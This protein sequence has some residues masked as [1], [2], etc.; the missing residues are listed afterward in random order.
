MNKI[1]TP[2]H[3]TAYVVG[4]FLSPFSSTA[5]DSDNMIAV[6]SGI[7][8]TPAI[9]LVQKY[10]K[11]TLRRV[12][13]VWICRDP[14]LVEH[15]ITNIA[16][17]Q[18]GF[19]LIYYTG[20]GRDI[21]LDRDLPPNVFL[22]KG[23]PNLHQTL[24]GIIYSIISGEGLPEQLCDDQ[25]IV[26]KATPEIRAKL[27]IEKAL[28]IY[29]HAQ[30][31]QYAAEASQVYDMFTG[32]QNTGC[33]LQS[34][35]NQTL[36]RRLTTTEA[37]DDL[38]RSLLR[39]SSNMDLS[40]EELNKTLLR[41]DSRDTARSSITTCGPQ[42]SVSEKKPRRLSFLSSITLSATSKRM[43]SKL[44]VE[45]RLF[46]H[47]VNDTTANLKGVETI[48]K[49]ILGDDY[50]YVEEAIPANFDVY[51]V[52]GRLDHEGFVILMDSLL[53]GKD[54]ER[55]SMAKVRSIFSN[56]AASR[57]GSLSS[58]EEDKFRIKEIFQGNTQFSRKHWSLLYCG[59]S[60]PVVDQLKSYKR[61]F[62]IALSI[63]KFDW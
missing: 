33:N 12:N 61:K 3:R 56:D 25:K 46:D 35:T 39:K 38:R 48:M 29:S 7:G 58:T 59:G 42:P 51:A 50:Q 60:Q 8:V 18:Y 13:L 9:S 53:D 41:K 62:G 43:K 4:P 14:G 22:F 34:I 23:R 10:S 11:E 19:T 30:L 28:S 1:T 49:Q 24:S 55:E 31:F 6:A 15:F 27:L 21:V 32:E 26:S 52:G 54:G 20:K 47:L 57:Q 17:G 36:R 5:M 2:A 45:D 40:P 44:S 37:P 63:E 16:F